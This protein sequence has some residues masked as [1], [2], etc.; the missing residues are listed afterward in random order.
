VIVGMINDISVYIIE[1]NEGLVEYAFKKI[2][3]QWPCARFGKDFIKYTSDTS[4]E[5]FIKR[6]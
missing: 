2:R 1:D 3:C 6:L 4:T 5:L